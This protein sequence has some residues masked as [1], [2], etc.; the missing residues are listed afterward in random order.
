VRMTGDEEEVVGEISAPVRAAIDPAVELV[1]SV[2]D[3]L[4]DEGGR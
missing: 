1:E 4:M 3:D 2:I